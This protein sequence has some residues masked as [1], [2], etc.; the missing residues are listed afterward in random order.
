MNTHG[1]AAR[2]WVGVTGRGK[3]RGCRTAGEREES[4]GG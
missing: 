4:I 3:M 2:G 1:G